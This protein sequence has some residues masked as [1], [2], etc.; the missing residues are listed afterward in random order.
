[1]KTYPLYLNGDWQTTDTTSPVVNPASGE[2]FAQMSVVERADVAAAIKHAHAAF[3]GWR[4]MTA[5]G[6]AELL[7]KIA[8]ELDRR[9]EEIARII[10]LENGK[11]INQS[12]GEVA[13][14]VDHLR[15][16]AEEGR[17]V[18]GR[19][20]PQQVESKRHLVIKS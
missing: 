1:M 12:Q 5:K 9:R 11:P 19:I 15:W 4:Q 10:T 8:D 2:T 6:R 14:S 18:Y 13:M 20:V 17:R 16:F 7:H 3:A